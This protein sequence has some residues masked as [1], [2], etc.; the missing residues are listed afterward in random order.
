MSDYFNRKFDNQAYKKILRQNQSKKNDITFC[1]YSHSQRYRCH[2]ISIIRYFSSNSYNNINKSAN[3][4]KI[5]KT[6]KDCLFSTVL[7]YKKI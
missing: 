2:I 4:K 1:L 6:K 7:N 3:I 5:Y